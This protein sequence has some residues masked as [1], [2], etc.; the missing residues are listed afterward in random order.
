MN[1][2]SCRR[3]WKRRRRRRKDGEEEEEEE[4]SRACTTDPVR[5]KL[6]IR[7]APGRLFAGKQ[8]G[9]S[10]AAARPRRDST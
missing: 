1:R 5:E 10:A 7:R 4:Y 3:G 8:F 6:N 2:A 9:S